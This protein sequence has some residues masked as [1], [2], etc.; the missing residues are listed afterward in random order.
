[1]D[2]CIA[3]RDSIAA[4]EKHEPFS[5]RARV[6][7]E[8][9]PF[10][11]CQEVSVSPHSKGFVTSE[12]VLVRLLV[13]PQHMRKD[14]TPKPAALSDAERGGL[15]MFR[16]ADATNEEIRAAAVGLVERARKSQGDKAGVFGVLRIICK[17][18][19][20]CAGE[21]EADPAYCVYDTADAEAPSHAEAFQRVAG[22]QDD[23]RDDRRRKLY[24]LVKD[25]FEPVHTFRDGLLKDLAP[26][27]ISI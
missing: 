19:R 23:L 13:A 17:T 21:G 8:A 22:I 27:S 26:G 14:K 1:M 20:E 16:E 2:D 11:R 15:S 4:L 18:I 9:Q 10:C 25:G 24:S 7:D 6:L 5:E 12:E 3:C